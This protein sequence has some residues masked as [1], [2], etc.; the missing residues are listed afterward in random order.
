MRNKLT[1]GFTLIEILVAL[2]VFTLV[3]MIMVSGLHS[4]LRAQSATEENSVV[5]NQLHLSMTLLQRD[6]EQIID[7]PIS[8]AANTL[9]P[10]V[11]GTR[12]EISMT[13]AGFSNPHGALLRTSLQRTRY[14]F[15]NQQLIRETWPALDITPDTPSSQRAL[16]NNVTEL[17]FQYL[18]QTG[19]FHSNWP[20]Q[21]QTQTAL[22]RAIRVIMTLKT[23]GKISQLYLIPGQALA[24]QH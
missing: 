18:D 3:S 23:L 22:P 12:T 16:L 4:V 15:Q 7:R 24:T 20:T 1:S 17:Q 14:F 2:F 6:A 21:G 19:K 13:H 8:N 5:F 11:T 10:A 9:T